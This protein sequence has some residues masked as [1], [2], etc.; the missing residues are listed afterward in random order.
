M[1]SPCI[2][3]CEL[4]EDNICQGCGRSLEHI[5]NWTN[6]TEKEREEIITRLNKKIDNNEKKKRNYK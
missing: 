6:Y 1:K 2:N 5:L 3:V 4:D